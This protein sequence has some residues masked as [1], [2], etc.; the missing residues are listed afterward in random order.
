MSNAPDPTQYESNWEYT[1]VT[2]RYH[3]DPYQTDPRWDT[4]IGLGRFSGDW[5]GEVDDIIKHA[6][7]IS[8]RTRQFS[9]NSEYAKSPMIKQEEH[10]LEKAGMNP[11][12]TLFRVNDLSEFPTKLKKIAEIFQ[13]EE[14]KAKIHVQFPGELLT[15][16]IDKLNTLKNVK[17]ENII[18]IMIALKDW[19][20][21]HFYQ[22]G[23]FP[24][25]QWR[26]GDAHTFA[27]EHVPHMTANASLE[28]R[29]IM[30]LIGG[31]TEKTREFL[32]HFKEQ[33]VI[34]I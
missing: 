19:V 30:N 3:F 1:K 6:R 11:T 18:R 26:K 4:V 7:A 22:Y 34:E 28:P 5:D 15:T 21:G 29:P 13:L 12:H 9:A 31:I 8:W 14:L 10:D 16:H 2:S 24:Y 17:K 27:W 33:A 23:N 25:I 20:P 32:A